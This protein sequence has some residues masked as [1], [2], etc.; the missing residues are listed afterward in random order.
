[1]CCNVIP[2]VRAHN[3]GADRRRRAVQRGRSNCDLM[4]IME[5]HGNV[6]CFVLVLWG[7]AT[8]QLQEMAAWKGT[9]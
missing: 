2:F 5:L 6:F 1:M 3:N 8:E 9:N 7:A 4:N